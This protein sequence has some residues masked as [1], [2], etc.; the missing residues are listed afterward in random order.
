[1]LG[2]GTFIFKRGTANSIAENECR[3]YGIYIN[4]FWQRF[5]IM[6]CSFLNPVDLLTDTYHVRI[7]RGTLKHAA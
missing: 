2:P 4:G 7:Q 3:V 1:M 6:R 5:G